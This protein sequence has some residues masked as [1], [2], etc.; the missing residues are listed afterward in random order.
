MRRHTVIGERILAAAPA[1]SG[2]ARLVRASHEAWDGSGCPDGLAD[3][4]IPLGSRIIAV[5][6]AFD[7]MISDRPYARARTVAEALDELRRCAGA[8][9]DPAI[10]REFERVMTERALSPTSPPAA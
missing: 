3:A 2:A 7:A 4:E 8:Q 6:D 1:L 10:V 5:C 9:F